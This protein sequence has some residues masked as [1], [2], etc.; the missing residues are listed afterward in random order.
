MALVFTLRAD[1]PDGVDA[2]S[3]A[4][5]AFTPSDNAG[6]VVCVLNSKAASPDLASLD[7][8]SWLSGIWTQEADASQ[9]NFRITAFSGFTVASPGSAALTASFGGATQTGCIIQVVDV[10]GQNTSD[11][12]LQP[13]SAGGVLSFGTS[14][15]LNGA[16]AAATSACLG[17]FAHNTNEAQTPV[18]AEIELAD[19][20]HAAPT[21]RLSVQYEINATT[22]GVSWATNS[23]PLSAGMEIK[24]GAAPVVG[25]VNLAPVIYGRGAA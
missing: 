21:R 17:F 7:S 1:N 20:G 15:T 2:I 25:D 6:I 10:T 18:G 14:F 19:S 5:P 3:F 22:S 13:E 4:T 11:F 24:A 23:A 9:S 8:P 12:V 16:L